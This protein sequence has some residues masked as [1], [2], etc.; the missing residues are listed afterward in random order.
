MIYCITPD[1][2]NPVENRDTGLCASCGSLQRKLQ[3]QTAKTKVVHPI[4]KVSQKQ[5]IK[6]IEYLKVRREYLELYPVCEVPEC[7]LKSTDIHHQKGKS[8]DEL[9]MDVDYFMAVC[10]KHHTVIENNPNWAKEEGHSF[11]RL[12]EK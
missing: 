3:R 1:C 12:T 8:T 10:R 7:N 6:N 9:L 2:D 4:K 11:K 5:A